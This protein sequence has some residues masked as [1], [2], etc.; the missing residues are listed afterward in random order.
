MKSPVLTSLLI[1][2]MSYASAQ[3]SL[4]ATTSYARSFLSDVVMHDQFKPPGTTETV[5]YK[6]ENI[7]NGIPFSLG[8][9]WTSRNNISIGL[10]STYL[11]SFNFTTTSTESTT[12][13]RSHCSISLSVGPE[14]T[15]K[16]LAIN[17]MFALHQQISFPVLLRSRYITQ[18][19]REDLRSGIQLVYGGR[20]RLGF[21]TELQLHMALKPRVAIVFLAGVNAQ[22]FYAKHYTRARLVDGKVDPSQDVSYV[23]YQPIGKHIPL[24]GEVSS[25]GFVKSFSYIHAGIG[26]VYTFIKNAR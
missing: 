22:S 3:V 13:L 16:L 8:V 24:V 7:P 4:F 17:D 21:A 25:A 2:S 23:E 14:I 10:K 18:N 9:Q 15:Y 11:R 19:N 12:F 26:L 1:S 6:I 20:V 5:T